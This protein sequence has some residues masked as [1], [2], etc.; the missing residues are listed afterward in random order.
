MSARR[1][2]TEDVVVKAIKDGLD[3]LQAVA[4]YQGE[5]GVRREE[6]DDAYRLLAGRAPAVLV[7]TGDSVS[8]A[9]T[10][11][12]TQGIKDV[13]VE[14]YLISTDLRSREERTRGL[15]GIYQIAEDIQRL[16]IGRDVGVPGVGR[17]SL[18]K[19]ERLVHS[20]ALCIWRVLYQVPMV[21]EAVGPKAPS[22]VELVGTGQ[23][24]EDPAGGVPVRI[25]RSFP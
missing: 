24:I 1:T 16:L 8:L 21:A 20:A 25:R 10:I 9:T 23:L 5:L 22:L 13:E 17:L 6:I 7:T 19:E 3:Y 4:P 15:H 2:Q 11:G 18:W 14:L 12:R